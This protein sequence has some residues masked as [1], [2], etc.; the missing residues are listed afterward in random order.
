LKETGGPQWT[1]LAIVVDADDRNARFLKTIHIGV[2]E[3]IRLRMPVPESF[4][5]FLMLLA[6]PE[7]ET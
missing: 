6:L 4:R 3:V 1:L 5:S 7:I 2:N